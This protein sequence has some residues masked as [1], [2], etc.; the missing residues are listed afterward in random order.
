MRGLVYAL[1]PLP[2]VGLPGRTARPSR[3][4]VEPT[5]STVQRHA[6]VVRGGYSGTPARHSPA[7]TGSRGAAGSDTGDSSDGDD[8]PGSVSDSDD[9]AELMRYV[10]SPEE[11]D[12]QTTGGGR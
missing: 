2:H 11:A 12:T 4:P 3:S 9:I 5:S 8:S 10:D 7:E 6:A 1:L